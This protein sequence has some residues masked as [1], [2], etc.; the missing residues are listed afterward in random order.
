M[1]INIDNGFKSNLNRLKGDGIGAVLARGASAAFVV[2]VLGAG[3]AFASQVFLARIMGVES[4]GVYIYVISWITILSM[5][6]RMGLDSSALRF[7]PS[8]TAH[9]EWGL[10]GGFFRRSRQMFLSASILLALI[11]ASVIFLLRANFS[12]ELVF[13]FMVGCLLL[14]VSVALQAHGAFLQGFKKIVQAQAPLLV[15]RPLLLIVGVF[16][17]FMIFGQAVNPYT[18]MFADLLATLGAFILVYFYFITNQPENIRSTINVY[19]T[20][21]WLKVS[22]PLLLVSGFGI[23]LGQTD[24]VMLG[25]IKGA[26]ESGLYAAASKTSGLVAFGLMAVNA[27]AAPMISQ[28]YSQGRMDELQR[29]VKLAAIAI[30]TFSLPASFVMVV[31]GE[32]ILG[33]FGQSFTVSYYP[34]VILIVG[35][36]VNSLAGSVGFLMTMTGHHKEAAYVFGASAL[37]NIVLN[38]VLIPPY[39]LL[40][41]AF[42]TAIT[43]SLWN[44]VLIVYVMR[45]LNINPTILALWTSK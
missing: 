10:L 3:L 7:V 25:M 37:L 13:T 20:D 27:I 18:A 24:I 11:M 26:T 44:I 23:L 8:Y 40:G 33:L 19:R 39:G 28:L 31:W 14:P 17:V 12:D 1:G 21:E 36:L 38:A 6:G 32:W 22:I 15:V 4:F 30:M 43:M 41:A 29:M 35:Q 42:A 9:E 45:K 16:C 34:L 5:L 2:K